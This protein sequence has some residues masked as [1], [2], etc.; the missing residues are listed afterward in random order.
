M[1]LAKLDGLVVTTVACCM[2]LIVICN[3]MVALIDCRNN[4]DALVL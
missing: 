4:F 2:R 1:S 3:G